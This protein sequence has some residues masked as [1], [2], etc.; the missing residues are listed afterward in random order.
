MYKKS[1]ALIRAWEVFQFVDQKQVFLNLIVFTERKQANVHSNLIL[2]GK[3]IAKNHIYK[4][5]LTHLHNLHVSKERLLQVATFQYCFQLNARYHSD[6]D[7]AI[8]NNL[9]LVYLE[10]KIKKP[11]L[12][13]LLIRCSNRFLVFLSLF[14]SSLYS[15]VP[16]TIQKFSIWQ[17]KYKR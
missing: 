7:L 5:P 17:T 11:P 15:G 16:T 4:S 13:T 2:C 12:V 1:P 14:S 3:L 9:S 6:N 8:L 10:N